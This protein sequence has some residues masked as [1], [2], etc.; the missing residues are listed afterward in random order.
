M[1]ESSVRKVLL[2]LSQKKDKQYDYENT[3]QDKAD[4]K[5]YGE[6]SAGLFIDTPQ[7]G[8]RIRKR[9]YSPYHT[10]KS[11]TEHLQGQ[12]TVLCSRYFYDWYFQKRHN[13]N[14]EN[15]NNQSRNLKRCSYRM[16]CAYIFF[17]I[18]I[19]SITLQILKSLRTT[20]SSIPSQQFSCSSRISNNFSFN[21]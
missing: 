19:F 15:T 18:K 20:A 11:E 16:S 2:R 14:R 8:F 3:E 13:H 1:R 5:Q 6:P 4:S 9:T 10:P 21:S 12:D 17:H 7:S